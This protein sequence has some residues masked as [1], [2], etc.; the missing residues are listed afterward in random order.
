MTASAQ[1]SEQ[2]Q[3]AIA[4]L[5]IRSKAGNGEDVGTGVWSKPRVNTSQVGRGGRFLEFVS[6]LRGQERMRYLVKLSQIR[7]PQRVREA[8]ELLD[9]CVHDERRSF[10]TFSRPGNGCSR[11]RKRTLAKKRR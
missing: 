11:E 10:A 6:N 7:E 8:V 9:E 1:H 2:F 5:R 3:I 4:S